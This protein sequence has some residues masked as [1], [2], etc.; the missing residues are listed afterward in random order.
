MAIQNYNTDPGRINKLKG[1]ILK[2]AM[3]VEVLGITGVQKQMPK[4]KG[5]NVVFR[6]WNQFGGAENTFLTAATT[7]A[8]D[9]YAAQHVTA[10]GVTPTADTLTSS[11]YTA[12]LTEY[13]ALYALTNKTADLYEDDIPAEMKRQ[14]GKRIG[15]VREMVRYGV[16]KGHTNPFYSGG[17]SR[18]TV[19]EA[20]TLN[21]LRKIARSLEGNHAS[22]ITSIL[23]PSPNYGT[24]AIEAS[25]LVFA[26][27]DCESDIRD[28]TGF[29]PVAEYGQRKPVHEREIGS[30]ENFRFITS[31]ELVPI[32]DAGAAVGVTGLEANSTNVDVYPIIVTGEDAW[33]QV[34]LRGRDSI[35]PTYIAPGQKDTSD[36][37]GQRG[38]IGCNTYFSSVVL[39]EGW[40][41]VLEAGVTAL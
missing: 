18:A 15:L 28:I 23:S 1:E 29:T 26:H 24:S 22:T 37:L 9:A 8:G 40:Y 36:P 12:T 17:T 13:S 27:T 34:A 5:D 14:V 21:V 11:D 38:Y 6:R 2:A 35:E 41:A 3:P 32:L 25:Y 16:L 33:G 10:E 4:N 31:P 7:D 39:N 20:I 19:D 30:V